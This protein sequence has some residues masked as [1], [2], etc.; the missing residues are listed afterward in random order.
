[1]KKNY[2]GLLLLLTLIGLSCHNDSKECRIPCPLAAIRMVMK[3]RIVDKTTGA[4]LLLTPNSPYKPSDLTVS[5][6][7]NG[8]GYRFIVDTADTNNLFILLD[9]YASQTYNLQLAN[10]SVDQIKIVTG[11][12]SQQCCAT[13]QIKSIMLNDSQVCAPCSPQQEVVIK[14]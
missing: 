4:D 11:P 5:S 13:L 12:S 2:I 9:D 7:L 8:P 14:K 3:V 1:M 6:S 10:L